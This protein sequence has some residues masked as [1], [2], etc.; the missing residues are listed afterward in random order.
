MEN[1]RK[2]FDSWA[3]V[4]VLGHQTYA[5]HVTEEVIAG[6]AFIRV[7]VPEYSDTLLNAEGPS[8]I[9]CPAFTKIIGPGS[10]YSITPVTEELA[11]KA[12]RGLSSPPISVYIPP[13]RPALPIT[14][15]YLLD[16]ERD[17]EIDEFIEEFDSPHAREQDLCD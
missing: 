8:S 4:E 1:E 3:I 5:G 15:S 11:R 9:T 6:A 16:E 17:R 12:R 10:I 2:P 13:D 14:A 7:D